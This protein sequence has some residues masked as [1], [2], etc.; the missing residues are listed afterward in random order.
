MRGARLE[1]DMRFRFVFFFLCAALVFWA[2]AASAQKRVFATVKPNATIINSSADIYDPSTGL[3]SPVSNTMSVPREQHVA[4]RLGNGRILIAGGTNDHFLVTAEIFDP[5]NGS[6][7]ATTGEMVSA[8]SGAAG[9]LLRSG[10]VFIAGG[11]NGAYLNSAETYNPSTGKFTITTSSMTTTRY[12]FGATL[13]SNGTVL[14]SGGYNGAFLNAAEVYDPLSNSFTATTGAMNDSREGHTSTL[15]PDGKVLIVG[16]CNNTGSEAACNNFMSSAELY[17]PSAKTFASTGGMTTPRMNHTATSLPDGRVLIIGGTNGTSPLASAEIYDPATGTFTKTGSMGVARTGLTAT[18]LRDGKILIT[19]GHGNQFFASAEKYD[20]ATGVF[21]TLSSPMASPRLYHSATLLTDGKVFFAGG[22]NTDPLVFDVNDRYADDNVSPNIYF[23]P[24]S[25]IGFVSYSG[26]GVV[27]AFSAETGAETARIMTG[28]KPAF[29]TPLLDGKTLAVVSVLDNKVFMIDMNSMSLRNTY[30]FSGAFGFGSILSLSPDGKT[31]YISAT[32]FGRVIKFDISTGAELGSFAG[33]SAPAQITVTKNGS[34]LL[35][36]DT[37]ANELVFV[38]A[39]SMT[40]KFKM[41]PLTNYPTT[42]FTIFNK[43]VLNQDE[44]YGMIAEASSS[45]VVANSLFIFNPSNGSIV[46]S[47]SIGL[48]PGYTMLLPDGSSW[49]VLCQNA[50]SVISATDPSAAANTT[51]TVGYTM[52]SANLAISPEGKYIYYAL[53]TIDKVAQ[54]NISTQAVVGSFEV[55]DN[56]NVSADQASNV[57]LASDGKTL[58]VMNYASNE[59]DLLADTVVLK[60][61][62][63]DSTQDKFTGLS[64]INTSNA[65]A[66]LFVTAMGDGGAPIT[67]TGTVSI[68]NPVTIQLAPNTQKSVD[69]SQLFSL[70]TNQINTG[71]LII[72]S[73]Q[74]GVVGYSMTGQTH[75]SFL[76]SY[77]SNLEGI[78]I[79]PDY[80]DTLHDW[81]IPEIPLATGS[82]TELNFVNPNYTDTLYTMDHY[83]VDG[84][85]LEN[86][87]DQTIKGLIRSTSTVSNIISSAQMGKILVVGGRDAIKTKRESTLFDSTSKTFSE[88]SGLPK[89]ARQGHTAILLPNSK[90]FIAGGRNISTT[91]KS[92]ELFD[93]VSSTFAYTSGSMNIERYRHTATLLLSGKVLLVGGQNSQAINQTAELFTWS[94]SSYALTAGAMTVPRDAHTA[95]LLVDGRVLITGGLDGSGISAT[96]EIYDPVSSTFSRTADMNVARAFHTAIRLSDG[97]VLIAGGYNGSY[98]NTAEIFDPLTGTFSLTSSMNAERSNYT[99]TLLSDNAVLIAGGTNTSGSLNTAEVYD[100]ASELFFY[101][102]NNMTYARSAHTATLLVDDSVDTVDKVL[103]AGG[104]GFSSDATDQ[105]PSA[106]SSAD[107]FDPSTMEFSKATGALPENSQGHTATLLGGGI[108]GYFR[109]TSNMGMLFT[110]IYSN[111][112]SLSSINGINMDKYSGV[113]RIF[114]PLFCTTSPCQTLLNIINGNKDSQGT[115]VITLH[116]SDGSVIATRTR[117]MS[118]NAQLKGSL[119]DIFGSDPKINNQTGWIEVASSADKIVGVVSLTNSDNTYLASYEMS[120]TPLRHFIFPF[121][122]QDSEFAT[123][124]GLLNSADQS[125][126]V[127]LEL[128]GTGGTLDQS[129]SITIAPYTRVLK[130]LE[131][132]FPG[133]QPHQSGNVRVKSDQPVYGVGSLSDKSFHFLAAVPPV[134]FPEQ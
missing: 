96:A 63:F 47:H 67:A 82:T 10:L 16:G 105:T 77:I 20:P 98:L 23:P 110:E 38:D 121:A 14:L 126:N 100:P 37:L 131:L 6:F 83:A 79:Y 66:T 99:A 97:R 17:D 132:L 53:S 58:A 36:V 89:L 90:V 28:G 8:R 48:Q 78:S 41:T 4:V 86:K 111:G 19:G 69:I 71:R 35:I 120:G 127:Q 26:S 104:F 118:K 115:V 46:S 57:A 43:A 72:E 129:A 108:Q 128:W 106:L 32:S 92:G 93:P 119:T 75:S 122:S 52:S 30:S 133:M 84:T 56:P 112:G 114:S 134:V 117:I 59:V 25:K 74:T 80:Q 33:M 12:N 9:L 40:L 123:E 1:N 68:T 103:I 107:I 54:Q 18:T 113:T 101:T 109:G 91:L 70:D 61:T 15:L 55:G 29:I 2:P 50:L 125:A 11:F 102:N 116:A 60:Q 7:A 34:T 22:R 81:I 27:L 13:L 87:A 42:S 39:G 95:T 88:T 3:F 31:G 124:I 94:D 21:T 130:N 85:L 51:E 44:T 65:P 76:D 62:K 64:L 24:N 49:L 73:F 45:Q 5:A